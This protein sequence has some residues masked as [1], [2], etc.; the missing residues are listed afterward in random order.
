[1]AYGN[2]SCT[3]Q[4]DIPKRVFFLVY[5]FTSADQHRAINAVGYDVRYLLVYKYLQSIIA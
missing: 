4:I 1:M 3:M 2:A 5:S